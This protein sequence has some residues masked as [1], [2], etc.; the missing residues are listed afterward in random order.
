MSMSGHQPPPRIKTGRWFTRMRSGRLSVLILVKSPLLLNTSPIRGAAPYSSPVISR[1]PK[2]AVCESETT[3]EV[4]NLIDRR[5]RFCSPRSAGHHRSGR[6]ILSWGNSS[7]VKVTG[8][9]SPGPSDTSF[10]M[11]T[12]SNAPPSVPTTGESVSLY[13]SVRTVRSA[14]SRELPGKWVETMGWRSRT[15]PLAVR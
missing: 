8:R 15:G 1:I 3:P 11:E 6:L 13:N 12:S 7:G 4:S 9:L 2:L 5:C 10:S 14:R